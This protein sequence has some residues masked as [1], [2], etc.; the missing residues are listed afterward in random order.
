MEWQNMEQK[1]DKIDKENQ[2]DI[3]AEPVGDQQPKIKYEFENEGQYLVAKYKE[4]LDFALYQVMSQYQSAK[5][6]EDDEKKDV[7]T[8]GMA[9]LIIIL[10]LPIGILIAISGG[11]MFSKIGFAFGLLGSLMVLVDMPFLL[12]ALPL[13][14]YKV[15]RGFVL[16]Q[17]NK[18]SRL[19]IWICEKWNIEV[20]SAESRQC[21]N[22]IRKYRLI[23]Q[24]LEELR[25]DLEF[26]DTVDLQPIK[27]RMANVDTKPNIR[28]VNSLYGIVNEKIRKASIV[29]TV[30]VYILLAVVFFRFYGVILS[31]INYMM[32]QM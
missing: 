11:M 20:L 21:E 22:Y 24:E 5:K 28:V 18:Q 14:L 7:K 25:S 3:A 4:Q 27:E 6:R 17:I 29:V 2:K 31:E 1:T 13:C 30:L 9:L 16:M 26:T 10:A 23:L 12:Y 8:F 15:M 32:K 19:G